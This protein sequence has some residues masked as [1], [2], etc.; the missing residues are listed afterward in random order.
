MIGASV[1]LYLLL[2]LESVKYAKKALKSTNTE[3]SQP[4][5]SVNGQSHKNITSQAQKNRRTSREFPRRSPRLIFQVI[6]HSRDDVPTV[7]QA[8]GHHPG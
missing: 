3:R 4:L 8:G 6:G 5:V 2:M 1:T 7:V